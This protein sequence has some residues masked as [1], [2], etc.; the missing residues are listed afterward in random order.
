VTILSL[1]SPRKAA[2]K[3]FRFFC[4]PQQEV[5]YKSS[6]IFDKGE[7]LSFRLEGHMVRGHRWLPSL[8]HYQRPLKKVLIVHGFESSSRVFDMYI[9]A[10]LKKGCEVLAFDAPAHGESG[11][12]RISLPLYISVLKTIDQNYGPIHSFMGHSLGGLTLAHFLEEVHSV[13]SEK[14]TRLV[15][16]APAVETVTAVEALDQLLQLSPEVRQE[17]DKYVEAFS[18]HPFSWF[19]L[20]RALYH[21]QADILYL[22]DEED[23]VTPLKDALA[24]KAD[25]HP[26]VH[27]VFTRGLGHRKIYKDPAIL[28][29]VVAFL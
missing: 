23:R 20:R 25:D 12:K 10:L 6:P 15:L 2:I 27:F 9:G 4:T 21:V 18:G 22:Q 28:E 24:V 1:V 5:P 29:Q 3:A 13:R 17:M 8:T 19:S 16:I 14:D 11:G 7:P 26:N